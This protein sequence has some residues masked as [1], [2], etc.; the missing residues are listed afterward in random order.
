M[1]GNVNISLKSIYILCLF[2]CIVKSTEPIGLKFFVAPG[3]VYKLKFKRFVS[4][5]FFIFVKVF[6]ILKIR[7]L[8]FYEIRKL[9]FSQF[10]QREH[11]HN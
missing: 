9:F 6:K 7:E 4:T 2:V 8:F 10:T 5:S 1:E 11:V 3:K